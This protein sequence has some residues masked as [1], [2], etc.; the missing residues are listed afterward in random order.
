MPSEWDFRTIKNIIN[1]KVCIKEQLV[2]YY[3]SK[4]AKPVCVGVDG[5]KRV[6]FTIQN[7]ANYHQEMDPDMCFEFLK[8]ARGYCWFG[9][10]GGYWDSTGHHTWEF[11]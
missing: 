6:E 10:R 7:L 3:G 8:R 1:E 5:G 11:T 9:G 2:S 4:E